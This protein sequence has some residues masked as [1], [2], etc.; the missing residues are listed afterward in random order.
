MRKEITVSSSRELIQKLSE[1]GCGCPLDVTIRLIDVSAEE[2]TRF[3]KILDDED[4]EVADRIDCG[5]NCN[6]KK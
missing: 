5:P 6:C 4:V 2:A 3:L 1:I